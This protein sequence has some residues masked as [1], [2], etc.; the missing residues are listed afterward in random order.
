MRSSVKYIL[1][2]DEMTIRILFRRHRVNRLR[3]RHHRQSL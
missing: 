2:D 3:L 1:R